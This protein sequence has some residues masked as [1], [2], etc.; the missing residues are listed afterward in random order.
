MKLTQ[1]I[2]K[3]KSIFSVESGVYSFSVPCTREH[4]NINALFT[5]A[6]NNFQLS[7]TFFSLCCYILMHSVKN[8]QFICNI[9]GYHKKMVYFHS[10]WM[11]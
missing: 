5:M 10:H 7:Y 8:M 1:V 4:K 2:H 6:K 11:Q 9:Q 3:Y